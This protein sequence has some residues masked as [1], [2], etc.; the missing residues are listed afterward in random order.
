MG[1]ERFSLLPCWVAIAFLET[2]WFSL[3][4]HRV[5]G[6]LNIPMLREVRME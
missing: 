1:R 6:A 4:E 5:W 2:C 3:F